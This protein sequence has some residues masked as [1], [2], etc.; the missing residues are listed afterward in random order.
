VQV[1]VTESAAPEALVDEATGDASLV[2]DLV[3]AASAFA[4]L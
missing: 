4:M 2:P 3:A 1:R